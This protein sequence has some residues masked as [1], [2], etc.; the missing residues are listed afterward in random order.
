MGRTSAHP[1][2]LSSTGIAV[3]VLHVSKPDGRIKCRIS[4]CANSLYTHIILLKHYV[5]ENC[6]RFAW[7]VEYIIY[8]YIFILCIYNTKTST[9]LPYCAIRWHARARTLLIFTYVILFKRKYLMDFFLVR[10]NLRNYRLNWH[11]VF[12]VFCQ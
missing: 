9:V 5:M 1:P 6:E 7:F 3:N 8:Y 11:Q 4:K 12:F 10:D 2:Q